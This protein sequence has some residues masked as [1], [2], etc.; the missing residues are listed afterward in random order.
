MRHPLVGLCVAFCL[1]IITATHL[2]IPFVIFYFLTLLFLACSIVSSRQDSIFN[3]CLFWV[4]FF[5]GASLLSN[6]RILPDYHIARLIPYK[7]N[8]ASIVG[9]VD[10]DPV[11]QD[12]RVSFILK[13]EKLKINQTWQKVCGRVLVRVFK[14]NGF[15][16]GNRLFLKGKLYRPFSFFASAFDYKSYLRQKGIYLILSVKKD[17]MIQQLDKNIGN[18]VKSF[19]LNVKKKM[20]EAIV[21]NS[22]SFSAGVLSA[23]ILGERQNLPVYLR[24]MLMKTGTVHIIA[25]SGLHLGIAAFI[26]LLILKILKVPR[27]PRYILTILLLIFYCLLTGANTPALRAT[28]MAAIL[29]FGYFLEREVDIY[30]S[31]ALGALIILAVNPRQLFAVGFQLSFVSVISIVWLSPKIKSLFPEKLNRTRALNFL[32]SACSVSFAAWLGLLPL[33]AY[34]FKVFSPVTILANVI[35]VPYITIIVA[36]GFSLGLLGMLFPPLAP[37]LA[38]GNELFILILFKFISFLVAIPGAYFTLA[39]VSLFCVLAYY[40]LLAVIVY[41]SIVRAKPRQQTLC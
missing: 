18:A 11:Y 12:A 6:S 4:V 16:Y 19:S 41:F 2:A 40:L 22:S 24:D 15:S 29:L 3:I 37:I 13:V 35:I 36:S 26:I 8:A 34:Y 23:V 30:N 17:S 10:S 31:L 9:V 33:I 27:R 38:A 5:L 20:K 28:V 1:G 39:G 7:S 32:I 21:T 14:K 25:I